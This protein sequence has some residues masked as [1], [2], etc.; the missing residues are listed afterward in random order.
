MTDLPRVTRPAPPAPRPA[1]QL[2]RWV[3]A[4]IALCCL[5]ELG[6]QLAAL[7]GHPAAR[8]ASLMLAGFWSELLQGGAPLYPGQ[9]ALM[10]LSYGLLH[11][12]LLHLA[13]NMLSLA[14]VAR[15]L[16][17]LMGAATMAGIYLA[18]Q[19]A[20]AA[21]FAVM[22]PAAG[23]MIGASGAVFGIAAALVAQAAVIGHRRRRPMGR[24]WRSVALILALNVALTLAMPAIAW[25]AHLG[26]AVAGA[27][28]GGALALLGR[29]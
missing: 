13:M 4:V 17:R 21:L 26:G 8:P 22:R 24:M 10:F 16:F 20:A 7:A 28:L 9:P 19:I 5:I 12:G 6:L 18:S 23:P 1:P 3:V 11:A 25:Q 2:P 14:V 15:E 29:R 27:L